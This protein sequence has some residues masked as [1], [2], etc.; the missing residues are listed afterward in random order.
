MQASHEPIAVRCLAHPLRAV[1]SEMPLQPESPHLGRHER[2]IAAIRIEANAGHVVRKS[3]VE[4]VADDGGLAHEV[5][6][7]RV[8]EED[9]TSTQGG[10]RRRSGLAWHPI[11][12][13]NYIRD[14]PRTRLGRNSRILSF[15]NSSEHTGIP[16][17][18]PLAGRLHSHTA[19][20]CG[21][22]IA[23]GI[24]VH[25]RGWHGRGAERT[26]RSNS[27]R[28][29]AFRQPPQCR[30]ASSTSA[31]GRPCPGPCVASAP[32]C[33]RSGCCAARRTRRGS[34]AGAARSCDGRFR[35][36]RA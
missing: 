36:S 9:V 16:P 13:G 25:S 10:F 11:L 8:I 24:A 21:L 33:P 35:S 17:A 14:C 1:I 19:V 2:R 6:A 23:S 26:A 5:R 12:L 18:F 7:I 27:V 22:G 31:D 4:V 3:G 32:P 30:P 34:A 29:P 15:G 20:R 28:A